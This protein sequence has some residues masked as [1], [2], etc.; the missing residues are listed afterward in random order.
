MRDGLQFDSETIRRVLN[1]LS[2][3]ERNLDDCF[4]ENV[5]LPQIKQAFED[6]EYH[7]SRVT[8][9][10]TVASRRIVEFLNRRAA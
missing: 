7:A 2:A 3:A 8:L 9:V 5:S 1:D 10:A 4:R 6:V